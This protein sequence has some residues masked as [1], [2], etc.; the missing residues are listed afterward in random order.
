[1]QAAELGTGFDAELGGHDPAG[2]LVDG[3]R[4]GGSAGAVQGEHEL[5][6]RAFAQGMGPYVCGQVDGQRVV[7]AG[8]EAEIG[9]VFQDGAVLFFQAGGFDAG[10][11]GGQF[12]QW[13][14]P[15]QLQG[16]AE[17]GVRGV[18]GSLRLGGA[19]AFGQADEP[20][21]VDAVGFER[22]PVAAGH[23]LDDLAGGEGSEDFAQ[24][25]DHDVELFGRGRRGVVPPDVVD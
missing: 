18:P 19:G 23:G 4:L 1:M 9:V 7:V 24:F 10:P 20:V 21:R 5:G 15:P 11:G 14:A 13:F 22:E 25:G 8:G 2:V 17:Q 3:Q 16:G 6:G 12:G